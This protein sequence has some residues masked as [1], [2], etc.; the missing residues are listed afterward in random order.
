VT[1]LATGKSNHAEAI[2]QPVFA[3]QIEESGDQFAA[4]QIA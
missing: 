1:E 2:R 3:I 4:G